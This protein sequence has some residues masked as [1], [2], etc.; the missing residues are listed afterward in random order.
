M[1]NLLLIFSILI[2]VFAKAQTPQWVLKIGGA[3]VDAGI[4]CKIAPNGTI[5]VIGNFSGTVDL[6]PGPGVYNVTS[7]GQIDVFAACFTPSGTFIWGFG[8][9]GPNR[10][11]AHQIA[12]DAASNLIIS[13]SF[14]GGMDFDPG[15]GVAMIPFGGG[16]GGG[17]GDGFVAKYS[18][19]GAYL[20]AKGL[21]GTSQYD[22]AD[23]IATDESGNIYVG[24]TFNTFM[25]AT[26]TLSFSAA[27]AGPG[28]LIKYDP[29]GNLIWGHNLGEATIATDFIIRSIVIQQGYIYCCGNFK[30]NANFCPWGTSTY[31]TAT[32]GALQYDGFV[33]KYDTAGNIVFANQIKGTGINSID[34]AGNIAL[35]ATGN[36]FIS[37]WGNSSTFLFDPSSPSTSTYTPPGGGGNY[38][39]FFAKYS[40]SGVFLWAKI[41]GGPGSDFDRWSAEVS[42]SDFYI[43][44]K[45]EGTVDF[46]PSTTSVANLVSAGGEDIFLARYD[47]DG[48]YKC[49]F[50]IGSASTNEWGNGLSIDGS[51]NVYMA[52][53]F[54]GTAVDFDPTLPVYPMSSAGNIDAF[55]AKYK[56]EVDTFYGTIKGDTI[57]AGGTAHI[58][59]TIT[60]GPPSPYTITFTNGTST[61]SASGVTSGVPIS[62]T[63]TP[64]GAAAY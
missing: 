38:D 37:G 14:Q 13:G 18:S 55:L 32:P 43:S 44:G 16:V 46:D 27:T 1:K 3:G 56:Y 22:Y 17:G 5:Y 19:T 30:G 8:M 29:A 34:E 4:D 20:W 42:G 49:A 53:Q 35:D 39:I 21:G 15:V 11:D 6:D 60:T 58:T 31:L 23:G 2:A 33:A 25:M 64:T 62:V 52:G 28:Y 10:E 59:V 7:A 51:G 48:N 12:V 54:A 57:C 41:M 45:F 40:N 24:G 9:G 47:L 50:R 61:F 63:P 36:I 26:P